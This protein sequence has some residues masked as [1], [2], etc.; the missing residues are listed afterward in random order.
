MCVVVFCCLV[1]NIACMMVHHVCVCTFHNNT[2]R[3]RGVS[4]KKNKWEAKVMVNRQWKYR[5]L[6]PTYVCNADKM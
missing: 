1:V 4:R 6:F 2:H 5:E 3:Y